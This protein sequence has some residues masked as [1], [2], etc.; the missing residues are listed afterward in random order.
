MEKGPELNRRVVTMQ[1]KLSGL[2]RKFMF[3]QANRVKKPK[4]HHHIAPAFAR[5]A[6]YQVKRRTGKCERW[7]LAAF[8][9]LSRIR[10]S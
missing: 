2:C 8:E 9:Y 3:L 10:I 1:P 5:N 4:V 6:S 7:K